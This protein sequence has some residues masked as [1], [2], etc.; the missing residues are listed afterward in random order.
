MTHKHPNLMQEHDSKHF[1]GRI[2]ERGVDNLSILYI[3]GH[4]IIEYGYKEHP[5]AE[6]R[7]LL[8]PH[9]R[10]FLVQGRGL[11]GVVYIIDAT[12]TKAVKVTVITVPHEEWGPL[13]ERFRQYT[14][15]QKK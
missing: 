14:S 15:T 5:N 3:L 2:G 7:P 12:N 1:L 4:F 10:A 6:P 8:K 13:P 11:Q 9:R